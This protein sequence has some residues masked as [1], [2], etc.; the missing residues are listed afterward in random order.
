MMKHPHY[1]YHKGAA[2]LISVLFFLFIS[3]TIVLGMASPILKQVKN[4]LDLIRSKES[5]YMAHAGLED[6]L[7]RLKNGKT[8]TTGESFVLNGYTT[9]I[10]L[11]TTSEGRTIQAS[12]DRNGIVRKLEADV[13]AGVGVAFNYGVQTGT[14]GFFLENNA[15]VNGNVYSN[16]DIVGSSGSYITG[17]AYAANS[18]ALFPDQINDTPSSI[19]TCD[20]SNCI[21]F[22]N[23]SATEDL[24]QSFQ[25]S[26]SS[27][28][29]KVQLFLKRTS[30]APTNLTIRIVADNA[31]TPSTTVLD[32]ATINASSVTTNF[33]WIEAVFS[34]NA[35][36]TEGETYW[37]VLDGSYNSTKYYTI[38]ANASYATGTART[39]KYN[40]T[41]NASAG[42]DSYFKIYL[43][44][45][46]S[47]ISGVTVG[48]GSTG[49]AWA[50]TVTGSTVRGN[51][52][53]QTGSGNNKSCDTSR[54]DPSSQP[55]PISDANI[56]E[57]KDA[58][59]EGGTTVG[60]YTAD[61][62][63]IG[64]RRI[65]GDLTITGT[66][67]L[68]GTVWVEGTV[69]ISGNAIVKLASNYGSGSGV[70]V[71]D[72]Y[73]MMSNNV[74]F[75]GSGATG[76]YIMLVTTSDCPSSVS[77][78]GNNA[79]NVSN[80]VTSVI[81]NAQNGTIRFSNNASAK[82]ATAK[83]ISLDNNS[84]ITYESGLA[85]TNFTSGPTGGWEITRWQEVQ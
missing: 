33:G 22:D 49:D 24:A 15:G 23:A 20:A 3:S 54:T 4:S 79:I 38:G 65:T 6:A 18:A 73:V 31:G 11:T 36:L 63:S 71:T 2:M 14:G 75:Q 82:E 37:L 74:A 30:S 81:L 66:V 83:L 68:T 51:L 32:T 47:T 64:P 52:Y 41:W 8:V 57:W 5:Y 84:Y 85:N 39:G 21:T 44:G 55:L 42:L 19:A 77:C 13:V 61:G 80:N 58:A 28:I 43:G 9:T 29:N 59:S 7:I 40:G 78:A 35:E 70:I 60:N 50:H 67:T 56:A 53:C 16:G 27:P 17:A 1:H 26:T 46:T 69:N 72:G 25:V 48:T 45:L 12:S 10:T 76:S 62:I 34:T